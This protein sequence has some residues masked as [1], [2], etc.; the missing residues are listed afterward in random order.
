MIII[1]ETTLTGI[2]RAEVSYAWDNGNSVAEEVA[3]AL[4]IAD[5]LQIPDNLPMVPCVCAAQAIPT[6]LDDPESLAFTRATAIA[7]GRGVLAG[8]G[9]S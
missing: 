9:T 7:A 6:R 3:F 4:A 5:L 1:D 8:T 2:V